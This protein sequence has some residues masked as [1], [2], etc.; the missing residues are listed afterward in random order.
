MPVEAIARVATLNVGWTE[1]SARP[2]SGRS[3]L[4]SGAAKHGQIEMAEPLRVAEDVDLG[5]LPAPDRE[6]HDR[7]R[8][9]FKYAEQPSGT[10]DKHWE[11]E[12]LEARE[13]PRA[14]SHLLRAADLDRSACQHLTGVGSEHHLWVEDRDEAVE[15]AVTRSCG[16]GIDDSSLNF[17]VR[18]GSAF[19]LANTPACAAGQLASRIRGALDDGRDLLEG[20]L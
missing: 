5:D 19:P 10:V 11:P 12:Q 18:I 6:A 20:H 8:L 9:S 2:A 4:G 16:K 3:C 1:H 13:A 14:T 7:E 15:V 17:H